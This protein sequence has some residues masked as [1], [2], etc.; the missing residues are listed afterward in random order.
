MGT[1]AIAAAPIGH[2][3]GFEQTV[4]VPYGLTGPGGCTLCWLKSAAAY[5]KRNVEDE[6][7]WVP[8]TA[9]VATSRTVT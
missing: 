8:V 3:F 1:T 2:Q 4:A 7:L 6:L 9:V 5:G